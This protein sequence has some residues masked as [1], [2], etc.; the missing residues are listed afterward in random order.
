MRWGLACVAVG[1]TIACNVDG[2]DLL[3]RSCPCLSGW[4]CD[5]TNHCVLPDG[6][7]LD[8]PNGSD[9]SMMA[10]SPPEDASDGGTLLF[11]E[12]FDGGSL[13][14][15]KWVIVG[16]GNWS[17]QNDYG[18]QTNGNATE[19]LI[20]AKNFTSATDYHIVARMHSTGPF[21]AG[22]DLAPEI[23][24]RTDPSA[25]IVGIPETFHCNFDLFE[26]QL[27]I[28]ATTPAFSGTFTQVGLTLPNGFD[29]GTWFILDVL[30][31]GANVTCTLTVDGLGQIATATYNALPRLTGSF[32]LKTYDTAAEFAY[33][34]VY[35]VP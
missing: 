13:D 1:V 28:Q 16:D 31:Q 26:S 25:M 27:L 19:T 23:A 9:A 10:D 24:F 6:A 15:N 18:E 34:R 21:D 11:D 29:D 2:V 22:H 5:P 8:A 14:P 17:V 20:Y 12:E 35:S 3:D 4:V 30:A 7:T 32:G 33:F